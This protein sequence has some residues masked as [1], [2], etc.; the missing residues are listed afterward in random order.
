MANM[1]MIGKKILYGINLEDYFTADF[2]SSAKTYYGSLDEIETF[3]N[4]LWDT[5]QHQITKTSFKQYLNGYSE[6]THY[7]AYGQHRLIENTE[8]LAEEEIE[9]FKTSWEFLNVWRWPQYM[10]IDGGTVKKVLIKHGKAYLRIIKATVQG[11]RT[12]ARYDASNDEWLKL[13]NAFWGH[14]GMLIATVHGES[15]IVQSALYMK[16]KE[17]ST[18]KEAMEKF[19]AEPISLDCMCEDVFGNG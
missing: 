5:E 9:L 11:L 8:V 2:C 15:Y 17:Y 16:E 18:K 6:V 19:I 12:A 4:S 14:P 10:E 3:I 7:I 1:Q 13:C